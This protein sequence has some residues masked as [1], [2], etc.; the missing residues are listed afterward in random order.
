MKILEIY[1]RASSAEQFVGDRFKFLIENGGYEMYLV[2]T[3]NDSVENFSIAMGVHYYPVMLSRH[4]SVKNDIKAIVKIAKYIKTNKIDIVVTSN[5]KGVVVGQIAAYLAGVRHRVILAHGVLFDTMHGLKK[6][7]VKL[8]L[9]FASK[10]STEIVCVSKSVQ[11]RRLEEG[12]DTQ[13]SNVCVLGNGS[14]AGI[15]TMYQFNPNNIE[16]DEI[17]SIRENLAISANDF[18]IGFCGRLVRDK[19]IV[20]LIEAFNILKNKSPQKRLKL[21]IIGER[22]NWD[23]I[24]LEI[25]NILK[26]DTD[27]IFTGRVPHSTIHKYYALMDVFVL[28]S[29]REGFPTVVMEASAMGLP[30]ITTRSTGCIDSILEGKTGLYSEISAE[31]IAD[32]VEILYNKE[33]AHTLGMNGREWMMSCFEHTKMNQYWLDFFNALS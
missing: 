32:A 17:S 25:M 12:I 23:G 10:L 9:K 5:A 4:V 29:F 15:D 1:N 11:R 8:P 18:I 30:V 22:E 31:K 28:P 19:G 2:A 24:P 21:L 14:P 27:I 7:L 33:Y 20:E 16:T 6:T 13:K 3:P 26:N